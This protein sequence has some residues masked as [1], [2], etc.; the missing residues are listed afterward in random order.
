MLTFR[1][2]LEEAPLLTSAQKSL[3]ESKRV[4][5][6]LHHYR[7]VV[8]RIQ[9]PDRTVLQGTFLPLETVS[10]VMDFVRGHLQNSQTEFH[11]CKCKLLCIVMQ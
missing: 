6:L 8:I 9:F 10:I 5:N 3:D 2:E 11:L 4:L 7:R 1:S